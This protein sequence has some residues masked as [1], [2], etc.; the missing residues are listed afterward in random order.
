M[1]RVGYVILIII[2]FC[3]LLLWIS[4]TII[5]GLR[6]YINTRTGV[7]LD[8][9]TLQSWFKKLGCSSFFQPISQC[10]DTWWNT[11]LCIWHITSTNK[12]FRTWVQNHG[13]CRVLLTCIIEDMGPQNDSWPRS[14]SSIAHAQMRNIRCTKR[15]PYVSH[16]H[17]EE[18]TGT[19]SY[20][21]RNWSEWM[22]LIIAF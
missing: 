19:G 3:E 20:I 14:V 13:K 6:S 18:T 21:S 7:S 2:K 10:L 22:N 11:L 17:M 9:Q 16:H 4:L 15:H 5:N 1:K 12:I 8:I